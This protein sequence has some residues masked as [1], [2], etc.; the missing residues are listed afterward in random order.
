LL[1]WSFGLFD[2]KIHRRGLCRPSSH[3]KANVMEIPSIPQGESRTRLLQGIALGV[4]ATLVVGF[5]WGWVTG[6]TAKTMA[7]TA[8]TKVG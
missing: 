6:G 1:R 7:V 8:E 3:G 2:M 4:I 5:S